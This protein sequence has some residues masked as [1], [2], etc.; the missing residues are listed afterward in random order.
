MDSGGEICSHKDQLG[1]FC[2]GPFDRQ[3][4]HKYAGSLSFWVNGKIPFPCPV[5]V[6]VD[7]WLAPQLPPSPLTVYI[8]I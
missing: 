8:Y 7:M 5:E 3:V 1:G 4:V 2:N 6:R